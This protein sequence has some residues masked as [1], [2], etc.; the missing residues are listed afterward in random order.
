[1]A[2]N[3]RIVESDFTVDPLENYELIGDEH[4][5][6][7]REGWLLLP[8][9]LKDSAVDAVKQ[10]VLDVLAALGK[11]TSELH[12]AEDVSHKLLQTSQY[13]PRSPLDQLINSER[14]NGLANSLLGGDCSLYQPFTAV[15][16]G[17]G[18]GEFHFHQ[19]NNYTRFENGMHGINIWFALVD[20]T[21]E[22]GCLCIEPRSHLGGT[23]ASENVGQG[24]HHRKVAVEPSYHLPV[25]M[26]AG[27]AVAFSRLTVHGSGPNVS[28]QPRI[29]YSVQFHRNDARASWD[30]HS[31]RLLTSE[32]RWRVGP[33]GS[34]EVGAD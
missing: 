9:L 28:G 27:D 29:G 2:L 22:N 3:T 31:P 7:K 33:V 20:M 25:R 17:G 23:V 10:D 21:P 30:D 6:Y 1:M 34:I 32:R 14:L 18:G 24:D 8:S 13:L 16:S 15:K 4:E 19:D 5:F 11:K 12:R 26:R